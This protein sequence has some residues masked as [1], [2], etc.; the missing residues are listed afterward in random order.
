MDKV[1]LRENLQL[2]EERIT[3]ARERGGRGNDVTI[4]G[5]TKG[6]P[7]E[8]VRL[9][10]ASG[11]RRCGENRVAE[12]EQKVGEVGRDAAEWHLI[13]HLQR[14]KVRRAIELFDLIHSIDSLRLAKELSA[15]AG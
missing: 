10:L 9:A 8:M 12:L 13:G 6:H 1:R 3:S 4:V 14:N 5:V 7:I 2:V 11:L 15:E